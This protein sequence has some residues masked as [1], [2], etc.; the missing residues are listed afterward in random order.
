[1]SPVKYVL[2]R[3]QRK[4]MPVDRETHLAVKCYAKDHNI[5]MAA[6][7]RLIIRWGLK[8]LVAIEEKREKDCMK[9]LLKFYK[10]HKERQQKRYQNKSEADD[11]F[12]KLE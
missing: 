6:A 4:Y 3:G 2:P 12:F 1:M 7:L 9:T 10:L 11:D 8:W 5:T